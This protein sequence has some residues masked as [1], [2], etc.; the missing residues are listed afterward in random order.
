MRSLST[1]IFGYAMAGALVLLAMSIYT[2]WKDRL[3][4][5]K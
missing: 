3:E 4:R 5:R 2:A 1:F